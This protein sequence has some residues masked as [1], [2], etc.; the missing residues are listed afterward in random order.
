MWTADTC[1][2]REAVDERGEQ[3]EG[4]LNRLAMTIGSKRPRALAE[5][6]EGEKWGGRET[7]QRSESTLHLVIHSLATATA[8]SATTTAAA[9]AAMRLK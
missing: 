9:S 8:T 5:E 4:Q 3:P 6:A 7:R 2:R 1:G